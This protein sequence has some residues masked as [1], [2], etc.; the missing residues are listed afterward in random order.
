MIKYMD[1][2]TLVHVQMIY[3]FL[4]NVERALKKIRPLLQQIL[5]NQTFRNFRC[6]TKNTVCVILRYG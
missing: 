4:T 5:P 6:I 3:R 2:H 1:K